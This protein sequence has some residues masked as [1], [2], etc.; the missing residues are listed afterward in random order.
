VKYIELDEDQV[1]PGVRCIECNVLTTRHVSGRC[2]VCE[3]RYWA[4]ERRRLK[5]ELGIPAG[6]PTPE[7]RL[8]LADQ[9]PWEGMSKYM[10]GI[11]AGSDTWPPPWPYFRLAHIVC[12]VWLERVYIRDMDAFAEAR[13]HPD[14]GRAIS[15]HGIETIAAARDL[16][17]LHQAVRVLHLMDGSG[18]RQRGRP[19]N[20]GY[21]R[22]ADDF[23]DAYLRARLEY[24]HDGIQHPTR[25]QLAYR[26]CLSKGALMN[27]QR[28][29][30]KP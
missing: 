1:D 2:D 15:T 10:L 13:W 23:H 14:R 24:M 3:A 30:G 26:M 7:L 8:N 9:S 16:D 11:R 20:S 29:W 19:R 6:T 12:Q 27:Y 25:E 5:E 17:R 28:K 22:S 18:E 21:F 4:P